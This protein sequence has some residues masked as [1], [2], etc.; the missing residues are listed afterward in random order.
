MVSR[1]A[2]SGK[3]AHAL[4][5]AAFSILAVLSLAR[6][7]GGGG[8]SDGV[9]PEVWNALEREFPDVETADINGDGAIDIAFIEKGL[10]WRLSL[11]PDGDV[12]RDYATIF[13][14]VVFLQDPLG[15][16]TFK[17]KNSYRLNPEAL[18]LALDDLNHDGLVD[19]ALSQK[20]ANTSASIC[21]T[22]DSRA[23]FLRARISRQA[24]SP[25]GSQSVS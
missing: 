6:C 23:G 20:N 24:T 13:F 5:V 4:L 10:Y 25:W 22:R 9:V 7:G 21:K 11:D 17:T 1:S 3:I 14:L 8:S 12:D 15:G 18:S 16:G 19:V 2:L